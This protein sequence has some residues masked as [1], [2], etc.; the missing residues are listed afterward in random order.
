MVCFNEARPADPIPMIATR[1]VEVV[2]VYARKYR[3][4]RSRGHG[5]E[6]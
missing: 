4:L 2:I 6:L 5:A 3:W 1:V